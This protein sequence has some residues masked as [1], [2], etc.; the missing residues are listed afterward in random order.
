MSD[1]AKAPT[2]DLPRIDD[3][4]KAGGYL[5][6][7]PELITEQIMSLEDRY[8]GLNRISVGQPVGTPEAVILEQLQ[9]FSEEILPAFKD[10]VEAV[11]ADDN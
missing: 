8:P 6:G 7:P 10:R 9:R 4:V 3:A 5:T 2:A 1:P 11:P